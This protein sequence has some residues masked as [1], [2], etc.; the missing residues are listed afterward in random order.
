MYDVDKTFY[1]H[2]LPEVRQVAGEPLATQLLEK[3][4]FSHPANK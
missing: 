4:V 2:F 3:H 1:L